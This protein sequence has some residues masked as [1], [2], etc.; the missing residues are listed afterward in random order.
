MKTPIC[1]FDAKTK[2]LCPKCEA[3]LKAGQITE[4]DVDVSVRLVELEERLPGLKPLS[5]LRAFRVDG[6]YVLAF[7]AGDVA[8]IRRESG[9]IRRFEEALGGRVWLV[10]AE[11]TDRKLLEDLLFPVRVLTVNTVWLPDGSRLTKLIIPGR[12]TEKFPI[13][14]DRLKQIVKELRGIEL[15]VEFERR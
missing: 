5:L 1:T 8:Q 4:V 9:L 6:D 10:E 3:K 12:K 2:I 13:D 7:K 14:L 11:T 15:L